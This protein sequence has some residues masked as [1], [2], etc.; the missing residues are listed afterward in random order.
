MVRPQPSSPLFPYTTLFR[1]SLAI[2]LVVI[3]VGV[4]VLDYFVNRE[5]DA[6]AAGEAD[7]TLAVDASVS[8]LEPQLTQTGEA[9]GTSLEIVELSRTDAEARLTDDVDAFLSGEPGRP[10]LLVEDQPNQQLLALV[11]SAV[12][13]HVLTTEVT[14][15]GGDPQE[16][17]A[18]LAAAVPQVESLA[19][20]EPSDFGPEYLVAILSISL[21]LFALI[22]TGSLI[23]MGVV[24]EKTS[25]VVEIL[26]ATIRSEERRVGA[27]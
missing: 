2:M 8:E 11:T 24:E 26:L 21:L 17:G 15:L 19:E 1:S 5:D 12:E 25:R 7:Y 13:S 14:A 4:F 27:E 3:V 20:D 18:A 10:E 22:G 6:A 9:L 23:A 16:V